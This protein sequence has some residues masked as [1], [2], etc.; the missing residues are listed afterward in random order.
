M[1]ALTTR[2]LEVPWWNI[3]ARERVSALLEDWGNN[4]RHDGHDVDE[5]IHRRARRVLEGVANRVTHDRCR[6]CLSALT[7]E[8]T[9]FDVLLRVVPS[10][11][12]VCHGQREEHTAE[13][14]ASEHTA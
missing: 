4:Q 2:A 10:T 5:N 7:A 3:L 6:V 11:T 8:V 14:L 13:Q 1:H 9:F 12:G